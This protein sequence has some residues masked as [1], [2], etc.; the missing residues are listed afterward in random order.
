V[1]LDR[2]EALREVASDTGKFA[3]VIRSPAMKVCPFCAEE[4]QDAA[5]KCK[6]CGSMLAPMPGQALQGPQVLPPAQRG[7]VHVTTTSAGAPLKFFGTIGC[8]LGVVLLAA[9]ASVAGT[10]LLLI[11]FFVFVAGRMYD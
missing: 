7:P 2:G 3:A 5:V 8:I 9:K 4:I 1:P 6:H 10:L 11:G